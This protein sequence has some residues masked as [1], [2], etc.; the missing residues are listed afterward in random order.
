MASGFLVDTMEPSA[1]KTKLVAAGWNEL[2]I[3]AHYGGADLVWL[4]DTGRRVGFQRKTPRDLLTSWWDGRIQRQLIDLQHSVDIPGLL[5]DGWPWI[6]HRTGAYVDQYG[7][8]KRG[9]QPL[10]YM[11]WS[12]VVTELLGNMPVGMRLQFVPMPG[13]LTTLV[14]WLTV[15]G[16]ERYDQEKWTGWERGE[17][18]PHHG[19]PKVQALLGFPGIGIKMAEAAL[20]HY[21]SVGKFLGAA[22]R[23]QLLDPKTKK[24]VVPGIG[25]KTQA[26]IKEVLS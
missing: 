11:V 25:S 23:G 18:P 9:R 15:E 7:E 12:H 17:A 3:E 4:T 8:F 14:R 1:L 22:L 2:S 16:P 20:E 6:N 13:D 21:G 24:G 19:D 5:V 10:S 26:G